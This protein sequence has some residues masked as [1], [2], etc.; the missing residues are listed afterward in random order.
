MRYFTIITII[1]V[2]LLFIYLPT[3]LLFAQT[4]SPGPVDNL[5]FDGVVRIF[6]S[7]ACIG[8]RYV[9]GGILI[10]VGLINAIRFMIA[11]GNPDLFTSAKANLLWFIIGGVLL[12]ATPF[13][14]NLTVKFVVEVLGVMP[15]SPLVQF[16]CS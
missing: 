3:G 16:T 14:I 1:F 2:G 13:I 5:N 4:H 6:Q 15:N 11:G 12:V 9:V 10:I 7:I 8:L